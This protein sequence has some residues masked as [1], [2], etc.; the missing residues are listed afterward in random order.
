M[1]TKKRGIWQFRLWVPCGVKEGVFPVV[2]W[3]ICIWYFMH[4]ISWTPIGPCGSI[5]VPWGSIMEPW[6][7]KM[8]PLIKWEVLRLCSP[9]SNRLL[10]LWGWYSAGYPL[11]NHTPEWVLYFSQN[12]YTSV[13]WTQNT[14]NN[15]LYFQIYGDRYFRKKESSYLV[16]ESP[17]IRKSFSAPVFRKCIVEI[18]TR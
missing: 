15:L 4:I 5:M 17:E 6:G 2:C 1:T 13:S 3:W 11:Q 9:E 16:C 12:W 8:D 18:V 10:S 7:S 14:T